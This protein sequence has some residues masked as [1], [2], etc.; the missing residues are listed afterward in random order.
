MKIIT[1]DYCFINKVDI[2]NLMYFKYNVPQEIYNKAFP[3]SIP[4]V[5]EYNEYDFIEVDKNK[6]SDFV[7][8]IKNLDWIIDM[9]DLNNA[10]SRELLEVYKGY[11]IQRRLIVKRFNSMSYSEKRKNY[12]MKKRHEILEYKMKTIGDYLYYRLGQ[13][14][15]NIPDEV[16]ENVKPKSKAKKITDFLYRNKKN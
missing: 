15:I 2:P 13:V 8:T 12:S 7:N 16:K 9:Q 1:N 4:V 3:T 6:Y 10:H 11:E 14:T 5:T